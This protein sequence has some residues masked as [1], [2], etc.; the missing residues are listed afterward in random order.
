MRT[1]QQLFALGVVLQALI[2]LLVEAVELFV[3]ALVVLG[4]ARVHRAL[5]DG[6]GAVVS[7]GA[8]GQQQG[9]KGQ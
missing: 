6:V 4:G 9:G 3:G 1:H 8:G 2:D 7:L 5:V